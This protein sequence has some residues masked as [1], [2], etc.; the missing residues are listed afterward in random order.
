MLPTLLLVFAESPELSVVGAEGLEEV[1]CEA[2]SLPAPLAP[3][4][5]TDP[6]VAPPLPELELFEHLRHLGSH[7]CRRMNL[8]YSFRTCEQPHA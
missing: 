6:E 3:V 2:K 4:A 1:L 8:R 7:E 5:A